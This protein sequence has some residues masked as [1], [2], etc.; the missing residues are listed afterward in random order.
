MSGDYEGFW[1]VDD[2]AKEDCSCGH[3]RHAHG[4]E[5]GDGPLG[6]GRCTRDGCSC[7]AFAEYIPGE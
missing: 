5:I 1:D 6:S 3:P 7:P 2:Y 4:G